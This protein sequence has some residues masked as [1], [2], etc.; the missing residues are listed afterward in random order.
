MSPSN[1]PS[2]HPDL[3]AAI[4]GVPYSAWSTTVSSVFLLLSKF[5]FSSPALAL[6]VLLALLRAFGLPFLFLPLRIASFLSFSLSVFLI[7]WPASLHCQKESLRR[8]LNSSLP[9][10]FPDFSS[11]KSAPHCAARTRVQSAFPSEEKPATIRKNKTVS[12]YRIK[13]LS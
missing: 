10:P 9:A 7:L 3:H 13:I 11:V 5:R 1:P 2:L 8:D 4:Y 12:H 6:S